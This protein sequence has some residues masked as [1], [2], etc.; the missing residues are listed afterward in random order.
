MEVVEIERDLL[1]QANNVAT[2]GECFAWMQRCDECTKRL[3]ERS[4]VKF[5]RLSIGNKQSLVTRIA[6]LEG[7]KI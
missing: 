3:E 6:R 2:L 5:P 1:E 7:A 4:R